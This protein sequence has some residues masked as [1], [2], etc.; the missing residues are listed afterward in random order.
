MPQKRSGHGAIFVS[1]VEVERPPKISN[2]FAKYT[3]FEVMATGGKAILRT[4]KDTNLGRY[5]VIKQVKPD[6]KEPERELK[7]LIREARI[8]AQLQHPGTV[9]VYEIGQDDSGRWYFAMKKIDGENLF[10]IIVRLSRKDEGA[11]KHFTLRRLINIFLQACDT[12][13][14]AHSRG[15]IHRDIKPENILVGFFGEVVLLDWGVAKVWGMP[16]ETPD[17]AVHDR[18][19]SPLYMSPEQVLGHAYIDERTDVFSM[20]IVLYELLAIREP[21]RGPNIR[22]TFD[23]II[24]EE[25][26]PPS[27]VAKDRVVPPRLE[28]I[29]LKAMRKDPAERYQSIAAMTEEI[30]QFLDDTLLRGSR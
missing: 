23:N 18:G 3:N 20:G 12:L 9:P 19:G 26:K 21:F 30:T 29:C 10:Q 5:V 4:C 15:V 22:A 6:I 2:D 25:P 7:R 16:N 27:E 28:E 24:H 14:Y 13:S 8:S 17:D 1:D 11:V